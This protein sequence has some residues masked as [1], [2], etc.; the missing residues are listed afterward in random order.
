M[1]KYTEFYISFIHFSKQEYSRQ[2]PATHMARRDI[3]KV[4]VHISGCQTVW[5]STPSRSLNTW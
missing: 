3:A 5:T 2:I 4:N 1:S